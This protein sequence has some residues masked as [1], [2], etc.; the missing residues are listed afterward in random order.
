MSPDRKMQVNRTH[1]N[2]SGYGDTQTVTVILYLDGI[3]VL[4]KSMT[5]SSAYDQSETYCYPEG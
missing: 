5:K 2:G 3:E 4:N 1:N